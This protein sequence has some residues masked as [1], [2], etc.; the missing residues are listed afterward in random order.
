ML[1]ILVID[2]EKTNP[3]L[4][5]Q[6]FKNEIKNKKIKFYYAFSGEEAIQLLEKHEMKLNLVL[7]D[8]KMPGIDGFVVVKYIKEKYPNLPVF[9]VTAYDDEMNYQMAMDYGATAFI[10]KPVDFKKLVQKMQLCFT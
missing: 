8:I 5:E 9:I 3:L 1:N 7:V 10:S 4:F 6:R 2:D